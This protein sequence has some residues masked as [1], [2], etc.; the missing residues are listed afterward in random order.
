MTKFESLV[1][2][3]AV[4]LVV[5]VM[6]FVPAYASGEPTGEIPA[7]SSGEPF[8][9]A[10]DEPSGE[11][12]TVSFSGSDSAE[13]VTDILFEAAGIG[14]TEDVTAILAEMDTAEVAEELRTLLDMTQ[15]M[16]DEQLREQIVS[17]AAAYG[18]SFTEAELDA[19]VSIIRSF[20][21]LTVSELQAKLEQMRGGIMTVQEVN[22]ALSTLGER[23]QEFVRKVIELLRSVFGQNGTAWTT[24]FQ[25]M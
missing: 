24:V 12:E 1:S 11:M 3:T 16:T 20:E 2:F 23:V 4:L 19:I 9:A 8:A 10:G 7:A 14:T 21:P 22:D 13:V 17:L 15:L 18:Y 6:L 5:F 25:K